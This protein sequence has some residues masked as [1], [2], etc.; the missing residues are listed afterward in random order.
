MR[1][2]TVSR[3]KMTLPMFPVIRRMVLN[4]AEARLGS[5]DVA[6]FSRS[7]MW[8]FASRLAKDLLSVV[9]RWT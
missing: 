1:M 9:S 5:F 6:S 8:Y 3:L 2:N 7:E 4:D